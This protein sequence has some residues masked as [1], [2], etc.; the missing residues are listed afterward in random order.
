MEN[1]QLQTQQNAADDEVYIDLKEIFFRL[2]HRWKSI[3]VAILIGAVVM[4]AYCVFISKPSYQATSSIYITSN[5]TEELTVSDVQLSGYLTEDYME[6]IQSYNVIS[7]VIDELDLATTYEYGYDDILEMIDV[8]NPEDTH[9]VEIAVTTDEPALSRDI[10][11]ELTNISVEEYYEVIG[12]EMPSVIDFSAAETLEVIQPN[13]YL[14]MIIGGLIGAVIVCAYVI[15]RMLMDTT[16][17]T[18]DDVEKY[19]GMPVLSSVPY[20][21]EQ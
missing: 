18:D 9:I 12:N 21:H 13:L 2:V 17:K 8:E 6:I 14:Y 7:Q 19:L 15:I 1:N 20:F 10:A 11:N 4:E 3:L 16:I 5:D